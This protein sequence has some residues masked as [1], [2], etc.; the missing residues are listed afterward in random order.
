VRR[1][2]VVISCYKALEMATIE[3]ARAILWDDEIGSL[4]AGK[5]ADL[6]IVDTSDLEL[7]PNPHANPVANLVYA[8]SGRSVRTV[9]I[10]GRVV[11]EDRVLKT[12]NVPELCRQLDRAAPTVLAR[13][14]AQVRSSWPIV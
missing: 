13:S 10:N 8:G 9:I 7:H 5:K 11:M 2:D 3:G 6:V 1:A 4:E 12:V 14:G